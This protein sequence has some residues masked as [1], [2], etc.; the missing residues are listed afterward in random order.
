MKEQRKAFK[1]IHKKLPNRSLKVPNER[2]IYD[3][4]QKDISP[5]RQ[6]YTTRNAHLSKCQQNL[7]NGHNYTKRENVKKDLKAPFSRAELADH[8]T[9]KLPEIRYTLSIK[10]VQCFEQNG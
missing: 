1:Q 3:K 2:M 8:Q 9:P 4:S 7:I 10:S 5:K 6:K